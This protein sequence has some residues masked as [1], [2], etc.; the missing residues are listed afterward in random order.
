MFSVW[1][2]K[3]LFRLDNVHI[4]NPA[5]LGLALLTILS[6]IAEDRSGSPGVII[7]WWG[8]DLGQQFLADQLYLYFALALFFLCGFIYF[9]RA[10]KKL[11][12]VI[13]FTLS[14]LAVG[15]IVI[16]L[17]DGGSVAELLG[18]TVR[19]LIL[20]AIS[21]MV[22]VMFVEPK[23][24]PAIPK[25]QIAVGLLGA[26]LLHLLNSYGYAVPIDPLVL[27]V[28]GVNIATYILKTRRLLQ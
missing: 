6:M 18:V 4:F 3:K 25:Q 23:T 12:Y 7:S 5:A 9:A 24:S 13:S 26:M 11:W 27:T 15:V 20:S 17:I 2:G 21:F 16:S 14:Y 19:S 28:L 8:A 1:F 22:L 10:F